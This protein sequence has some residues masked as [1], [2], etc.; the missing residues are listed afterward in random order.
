MR[1]N[2]LRDIRDAINDLVDDYGPE[3]L[4]K[5]IY[6]SCDYGDY[7]HTQQLIPLDSVISLVK[8][9]KTPYSKSGLAVMRDDKDGWDTAQEVLLI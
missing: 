8:A 3:I 5:D 4:D 1:T 6:A 9:D 7:G 2:T